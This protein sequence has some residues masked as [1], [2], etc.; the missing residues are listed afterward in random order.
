[1]GVLSQLASGGGSAAVVPTTPAPAPT[2]GGGGIL[3]ALA[4][5]SPTVSQEAPIQQKLDVAAKHQGGGFF[6]H[7]AGD[8]SGVIQGIP[9]LGELAVKNIAAIPADLYSA[10]PGAPGAK[11]A[12]HFAMGVA[13]E[14]LKAGKGILHDY[15][16]RYGP[17][18]RS[19]A[20]L[21]PLAAAENFGSAF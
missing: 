16:T 10:I 5:D 12:R 19:I 21:H 2:G 9:S 17:T 1:V 14:D 18:F 13:N 20:H 6:G 3:S 15:A 8:I 11:G 7:L 4:S